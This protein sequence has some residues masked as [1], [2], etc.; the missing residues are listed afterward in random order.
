MLE[1]GKTKNS[2]KEK[3]NPPPWMTCLLLK[4]PSITQLWKQQENQRVTDIYVPGLTSG[5]KAADK[6]EGSS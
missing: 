2:K 3:E 5:H 6:K 1:R 4:Y